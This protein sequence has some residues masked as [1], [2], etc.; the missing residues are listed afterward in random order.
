MCPFQRR[1]EPTG[2]GRRHPT[3]PLKIFVGG[4]DPAVGTED[5]RRHFQVRWLGWGQFFAP[6]LAR[7]GVSSL[8]W[9]GRGLGPL[10]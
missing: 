5:M 10:M 8:L 6:G 7:F 4:L 1:G 3:G 9:R 2:G